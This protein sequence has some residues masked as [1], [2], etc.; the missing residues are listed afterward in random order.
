MKR[1]L[2][3]A[4]LI[5]AMTTMVVSGCGKKEETKS[6]DGK[7][8]IQFMHQQ[9]EQERQDA[10][11]LYTST[12]GIRTGSEGACVVRPFTSQSVIFHL[13]STIDGIVSEIIATEGDDSFRFCIVFS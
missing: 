13:G 1:K 11:L 5:A 4:V 10:C 9:V 6:E 3:F 12:P 8:H 2:V 7:V